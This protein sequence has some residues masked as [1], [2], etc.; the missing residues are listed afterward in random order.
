MFIRK[1]KK[2]SRTAAFK[3]RPLKLPVSG[4][5]ELDAGGLRLTVQLDRPKWQRFLGASNKATCSFELDTFGREVYEACDGKNNVNR[6]IKDFAGAHNITAAEA[7]ISVTTFLKT[8]MSRGLV[9][10]EFDMEKKQQ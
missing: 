4:A 1:K 6:I 9:G 3:A 5:T 7:E 8:L 2:I 10:M